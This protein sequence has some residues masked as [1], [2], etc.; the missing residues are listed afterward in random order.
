MSFNLGTG[1]RPTG[2][3]PALD[4]TCSMRTGW[5][6]MTGSS[7]PDQGGDRGWD[8][9][10]RP[11]VPGVPRDW[12]RS[13]ASSDFM[14][15]SQMLL[16]PVA[17]SA[18]GFQGGL[19]LVLP[20]RAFEGLNPSSLRS[21]RIE[22]APQQRLHLVSGFAGYGADRNY[23]LVDHVGDRVQPHGPNRHA[24][25]PTGSTARS[26]SDTRNTACRPTSKHVQ[27]VQNE[28][29]YRFEIMPLG[30][31]LVKEDRIKRL[32]PDLRAGAEIFPPEGGLVRHDYRGPGNRRD[33]DVHPGGIFAFPV[34]AHDDSLD[35][36]SRI[37]G[38]DMRVEP[39]L[40][41]TSVAR[42]GATNSSPI[43]AARIC[44]PS[45]RGRRFQ[46]STLQSSS[47]LKEL[48]M[49]G[50]LAEGG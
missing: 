18:Q 8:R 15:A 31:Q 36:R 20:A 26:G 43:T 29:N 40:E 34:L 35:P 25:P 28:K 44:P 30:G 45:G 48:S 46:P 39:P 47:H 6:S 38:E 5:R 17:D 32:V 1:D 50:S 27:Y 33:Q 13:G 4:T 10:P 14:F 9:K 16:E 37:L 41:I 22:E 7:H 11:G 23:Y 24:V 19:A 12:R 21:R 49:L 2:P 42:A 3:C